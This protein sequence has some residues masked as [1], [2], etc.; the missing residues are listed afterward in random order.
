MKI[1]KEPETRTVECDILIYSILVLWV[2]VTSNTRK[3]VNFFF[4]IE[5]FKAK[6]K[7]KEPGRQGEGIL[8]PFA[9]TFQRPTNTDSNLTVKDFITKNFTEQLR[10]KS[11]VYTEW[12]AIWYYLF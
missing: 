5:V 6:K 9:A 11:F 10:K 4:F 12:S 8:F 3:S 7:K 1:D 2:S